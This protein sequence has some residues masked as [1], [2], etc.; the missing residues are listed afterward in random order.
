[1]I[2]VIVSIVIVIVG[3]DHDNDD[4]DDYNTGNNFAYHDQNK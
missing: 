2:G 4:N 1:M 3:F